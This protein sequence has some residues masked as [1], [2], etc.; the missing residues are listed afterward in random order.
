MTVKK[1]LIIAG[2]VLIAIVAACILV[3]H[4]LTSGRIDPLALL[5]LAAGISIVLPMVRTHFIPSAADCSAELDF[6]IRRQDAFVRQQVADKLG[7]EAVQRL[8]AVAD[9]AAGNP[10]NDL[11]GSL[12]D[13]EGE[14]PDADLRFAL[15]IMLSRNCEKTGDPE[16]AIE[17]LSEALQSRPQDFVTRLSLARNLEWQGN[18]GGALEVYQQI[19]DNTAGLSRA[20]IKLTRRQVEVLRGR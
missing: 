16:A 20:M 14:G 6:H 18:P 12:V 17:Y 3:Y 19:L 4:M 13:A 5:L 11:L 7:P 8:E 15:L 1:G 10:V 9:G 2:T